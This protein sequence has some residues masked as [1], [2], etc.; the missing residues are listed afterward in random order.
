MNKPNT[1]IVSC[2][3]CS[4]SHCWCCC[5]DCWRLVPLCEIQRDWLDDT[6]RYDTTRAFI[7]AVCRWSTPICRRVTRQT[8]PSEKCHLNIIAAY[9]YTNDM[10][11]G[12]LFQRPRQGS[13]QN[14]DSWLPHRQRSAATDRPQ[15]TQLN[16]RVTLRNWLVKYE[17]RCHAATSFSTV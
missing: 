11:S 6:T 12:R 1:S 17:R 7:D 2:C 13:S 5:C 16:I 15:A 3:E 10:F 4:V 8:V 14:A 9:L